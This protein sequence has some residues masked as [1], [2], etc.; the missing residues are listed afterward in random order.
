MCQKAQEQYR[1]FA[2]TILLALKLATHQGY[3]TQDTDYSRSIDMK[4]FRYIIIIL[5]SH[6]ARRTYITMVL[7]FVYIPY[8]TL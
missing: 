8:L 5:F 2:S 6:I 7:S 3:T 4:E 1:N